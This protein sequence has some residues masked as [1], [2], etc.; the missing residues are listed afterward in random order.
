MLK[1][2]LIVFEYYDL[3]KQLENFGQTLRYAE[4]ANIIRKEKRLAFQ[5]ILLQKLSRNSEKKENKS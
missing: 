2:Q 1:K 3:L 5:E 4:L